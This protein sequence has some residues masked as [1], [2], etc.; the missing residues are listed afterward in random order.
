[1]ELQVFSKISS[2]NEITNITIKSLILDTI[3]QELHL[4]NFR[5]QLL[6]NYK[7]LDVLKKEQLFVTP[8]I[9]GVNSI[10]IFLEHN[11]KRYQAIIAKKDLKF[12]KNQININTL[13]IY[14]FWIKHDD[15]NKFF[16]LS[17]FDGK[18][19]LNE[20]NLTYLIHDC[21]LFNG[22]KILTKNICDKI[23]LIN[24]FLPILNQNIDTSKFDIKMCAIYDINSIS[25]LIFN[26]IKNSKLK[27]NGLI[28]IPERSGKTYI[29]INDRE[30]GSLRNNLYDGLIDKKFDHLTVPTVPIN[31]SISNYHEPN[32][33]QEF[34]IKKTNLTDVFE[35]Y[36]YENQDK[37]YLNIVPD[38]RVGIAHIP[39]I[40]TSQYC[41]KN[42]LEKEIFIQKCIFNNKFKK[43][44]PICEM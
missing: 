32:M 9:M 12:S 44:I 28:F 6:D 38:N 20:N 3:Y 24:N 11:K 21:Y 33:I 16:P 41:K 35:L 1:M 15:C 37:I 14:N 7:S 26:K 43:W 13:K 30:F 34:V 22:E 40:K 31:M 18:F 29:Y 23:S 36:H 39:D 2:F 4:S 10:I 25:D 19:I 8:H 5:Y 42:G 27:I 17:I